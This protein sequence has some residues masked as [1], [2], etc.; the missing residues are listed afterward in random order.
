MKKKQ[1][2]IRLTILNIKTINFYHKNLKSI[3]KILTKNKERQ[4][5]FKIRGFA[6]EKTGKKEKRLA[7]RILGKKAPF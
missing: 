5:C 3:I 2:N 4:S 1:L 7:K 6:D